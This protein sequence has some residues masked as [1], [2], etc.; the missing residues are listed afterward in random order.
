MHNAKPEEESQILSN[1][2]SAT[3]FI[4]PY[5]LISIK[6]FLCLFKLESFKQLNY[7]HLNHDEG[8]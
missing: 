4:N 6:T 5:F 7:V 1:T 8:F 2:D 3:Y